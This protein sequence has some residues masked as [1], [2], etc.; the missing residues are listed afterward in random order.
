MDH[1]SKCN[2]KSVKI[3]EDNIGENL[4]GHGFGNEVLD[5]TSKSWSMKEKFVSL[6]LIQFKNYFFVKGYFL[7]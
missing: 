5:I 6:Y 1:K 7:S 3:L 2:T 4:A